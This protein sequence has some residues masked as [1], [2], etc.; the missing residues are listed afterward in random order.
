LSICDVKDFAR[1]TGL[2]CFLYHRIDELQTALAKSQRELGEER[3][4]TIERLTRRAQAAMAAL[5]E[6]KMA[7][8][9][10]E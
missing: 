6:R 8:Q 3:R 7:R 10:R 5:V 4:A 1:R 2:A 9:C